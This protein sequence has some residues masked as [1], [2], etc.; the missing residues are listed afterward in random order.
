MYS[1]RLLDH[2]EHPR[3]PG[4]ITN[5]DGAAQVENP[6]CADI[7]KITIRLEGARLAD[8]RFQCKGCVPAIACASALTELVKGKTIDE[9]MQLTREQIIEFLGGV[10]EASTH[11]AQLAIDSLNAALSMAKIPPGGASSL[12][13]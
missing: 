6:V 12:K 9:A 10:P 13:T 2:F 7:L 4:E 11:A 3:N 8:I 1:P 5:P